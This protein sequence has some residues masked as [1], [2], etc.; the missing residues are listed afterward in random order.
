MDIMATLVFLV[1]SDNLTYII[2]AEKI[3]LNG[4]Q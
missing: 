2:M 4:I 3:T 1:H